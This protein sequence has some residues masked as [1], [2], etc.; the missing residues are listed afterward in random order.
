VAGSDESR[1][2]TNLASRLPLLSCSCADHSQLST[3]PSFL[4]WCPLFSCSVLW[5][6]FKA[7]NVFC[8][9]KRSLNF[10]QHKPLYEPQISYSFYFLH[11]PGC[12]AQSKVF[13]KKGVFNGNKLF[14]FWNSLKLVQTAEPRCSW[15]IWTYITVTNTEITN[16]A[17]HFQ[18]RLDS[19]NSG[20]TS[21]KNLK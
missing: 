7:F 1:Q 3:A 2:T 11:F 17:T 14:K 20:N 5:P 16:T 6:L 18:W 19:K 15:L 13:L 10:T 12:L 9:S 8:A 21:N 4:K